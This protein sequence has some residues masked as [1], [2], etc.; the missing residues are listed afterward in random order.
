MTSRRGPARD[1]ELGGRDS[2]QAISAQASSRW[3]IALAIGLAL[4]LSVSVS[5]Q[6]TAPPQAAAPATPAPDP[7]T[8][9][10]DQIL[11]SFT[12]AEGSAADFEAVIAKVKEVLIKSEK[13][14]RKQQAAHWKILKLEGA[15]G[16]DLTYFFLIDQVVK[17]ASYDPFK[18]L[19]E[20]LPPDEVKKLY[21]KVSAGVKGIRTA[22]LGKIFDMGGAI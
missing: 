5:A 10:V 15:P 16:S 20:G 8:F 6:Q 17:G 22:P 14:E 19:A 18:I 12:I 1:G 7:M 2:M 4:V 9:S 21:D 13:P 11:V 3:R